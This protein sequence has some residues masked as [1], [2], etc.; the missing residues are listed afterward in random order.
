MA[1]CVGATDFIGGA[2][3]ALDALDGASFS[4]GD[5][6]MVYKD[7]QCVPYIFVSSSVAEHSPWLIQPDTN[8]EGVRWQAVEDSSLNIIR[9]NMSLYL[10]STGN[11]ST[12][13]GMTSGS[14]W[15]TL[16]KAVEWLGDKIILPTVTVTISIDSSSITHDTTVTISGPQF[17]RVVID[18]N[19]STNSTLTWATANVTGIEI[20]DGTLLKDIK[21]VKLAGGTSGYGIY[22]N[23][24]S[25]VGTTNDLLI[26]GFNNCAFLDNDS[27][28][29]ASAA[30]TFKNANDSGVIATNESSA[31]VQSCTFDNNGADGLRVVNG[32][33]ANASSSTSTNNTGNG[34]YAGFNS[35]IKANGTTVSGNGTN[36]SPAK[37]TANDPTFGNSGSWIYG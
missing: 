13:T 11:D 19:G 10:A 37:T 20:V 14:P 18:G 21:D 24:G 17:R 23:N 7:G 27:F 6:A 31:R 1:K 34:Y 8:G 22:L 3:G 36:Y 32:S 15:K 12:N 35:W 2:A 30:V 28:F 9:A 5:A 26:D 29:N 4:A 16:N 33:Q 25:A